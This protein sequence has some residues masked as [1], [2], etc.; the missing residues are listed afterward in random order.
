MIRSFHVRPAG[1]PLLALAS[2]C[3]VAVAC[4]AAPAFAQ[5]SRG[6]AAE[7]PE[8]AAKPLPGAPVLLESFGD[9]GAYTAQSGKAKT[10]YALGKPKDRQPSGLKR[11]PG[12]VFISNR[13]GESVKNEV[14]IVMG[15]EVKPDSNPKAEIGQTSFE[16]VA[17]GANLWLKNAAQ[18]SQFVEALRKGQ[19]LVVKAVSKKGNPTTDSYTLPGVTPALDRI[20]KACV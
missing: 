20:G 14:S 1:R 18:E 9:W 2:A 10:C 7:K 6:A 19:R 13:P 3:V 15:F 5:R 11:D 8:A 17:K 16:M 12:Y 4:G